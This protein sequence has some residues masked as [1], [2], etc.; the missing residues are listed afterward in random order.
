MCALSVLR[1]DLAYFLELQEVEIIH[2]GLQ[3]TYFL[4]Q[5]ILF[6]PD[7]ILPILKIDFP[8]FDHKLY[9]F[10][11]FFGSHGWYE[12]TDFVAV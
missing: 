8:V 10:Q 6:S 12:G 3:S 7:V 4:R 2:L 11:C 1:T 9:D 5:K